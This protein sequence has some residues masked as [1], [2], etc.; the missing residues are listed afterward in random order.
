V[1]TR[2][3]RAEDVPEQELAFA[4]ERNSEFWKNSAKILGEI[5]EKGTS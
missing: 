2:A 3:R 1:N 4:C 5:W